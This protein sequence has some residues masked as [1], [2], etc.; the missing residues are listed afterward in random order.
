MILLGRVKLEN[1]VFRLPL[2]S[3][4]TIFREYRI[5]LGRVKL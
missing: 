5:R 3:P 2:L 4:F 1:F